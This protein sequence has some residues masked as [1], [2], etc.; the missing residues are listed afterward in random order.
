MSFQQWTSS[1]VRRRSTNLA[2]CTTILIKENE[3]YL[4]ESSSMT[5][6]Q[7]GRKGHDAGQYHQHAA[8]AARY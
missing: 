1:F 6:L 5:L 8:I 2:L 7:Q 3:A 4:F